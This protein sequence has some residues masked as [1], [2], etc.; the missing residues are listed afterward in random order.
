MRLI[1]ADKLEKQLDNEKWMDN[2]D[3]D[4]IVGV[5]LDEAPN[6]DAVEVVRGEWKPIFEGANTHK[7]SICGRDGFSDS[8]YGFVPTAYCSHCGARM[9]VERRE[10][11]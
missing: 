11:T 7:C 2:Y 6:V 9:Y 8:D 5:A 1:D 3:R 4:F 10:D